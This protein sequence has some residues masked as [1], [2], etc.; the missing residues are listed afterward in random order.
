MTDSTGTHP[1]LQ[2]SHP[3][4]HTLK[5]CPRAQCQA[6]WRRME[7]DNDLLNDEVGRTLNRLQEA[8]REP[9]MPNDDRASAGLH[10]KYDV[11]RRSTGEHV[12]DCF[13]LRLDGRDYHAIVAIRAYA[14]SCQIEYPDL[15]ADLLKWAIEAE[16]TRRSRWLRASLFRWW[17]IV[18]RPAR[19]GMRDN[20][21]G[22]AP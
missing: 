8:H 6:E 2:E 11:V 9:T 18:V 22:T 12:R 3:A 17:W 1:T 10:H 15:A 5:V 16:A 14:R 7:R 13:V 20:T 4:R 19:F 21:G